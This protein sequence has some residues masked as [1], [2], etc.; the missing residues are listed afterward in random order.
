M[1]KYLMT[2]AISVIFNF[3]ALS[4]DSLTVAGLLK[5]ASKHKNT[6]EYTLYLHKADSLAIRVGDIPNRAAI[7]EKLAFHYFS[8][9]AGKSL[10]HYEQAISLYRQADNQKKMA[11]CTQNMAFV[12][13][14]GLKDNIN[15]LEKA[16]EA[17][18]LW[19]QQNDTMQQA[20]IYKYI[21][22]LEGRLGQYR[23]AKE[24]ISKAIVLFN[25]QNYTQGIAV[26]YFDLANVLLEEKDATSAITQLHKAKTIWQGHKDS[27]RIYIINTALIKGFS[28]NG[29]QAEIKEL[30]KENLQIEQQVEIY[31]SN[32]LDFYKEA[33][34]VTSSKNK[35]QA[36]IFDMKY[37]TLDDSLTKEGI[38]TR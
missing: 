11:M 27:T 4:Q 15:A 5:E 1:M 31:W 26:C 20:N 7:Q 8:R 35:K 29:S 3:C 2:V 24:N 38:K 16:G 6:P 36:G 14:E 37:R 12:Y 23:A 19:R 18:Q 17:L 25:S 21:G 34:G 10:H 13:D 32:R 33:Q 28:A 9:N 22:L 30:L